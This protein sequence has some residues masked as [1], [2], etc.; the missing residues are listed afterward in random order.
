MTESDIILSVQ[1]AAAVFQ[2][3]IA[4]AIAVG[5][6]RLTR[7]ISTAEHRR[8]INNAWQ[9][10][11]L[12]MLHNECLRKYF[13]DVDTTFAKADIKTDAEIA[14]CY[15][16][17]VRLNIIYETWYANRSKFIDA[18]FSSPMLITQIEILSKFHSKVLKFCLGSG[19]SE[20]FVEFV[21]EKAGISRES[22]ARRTE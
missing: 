2:L 7:T 1:A 6:H 13:T 12:E 20:E 22:I 19:Y 3:I 14:A 17:F 4:A 15:F 9:K 5:V 10:Y 16:V 21:C 11:N 18:S 8:E